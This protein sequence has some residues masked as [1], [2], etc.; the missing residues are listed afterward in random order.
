VPVL[1]NLL[2]ARVTSIT[3]THVSAQTAGGHGHKEVKCRS[4][5]VATST[6]AGL[7]EYFWRWQELEASGCKLTVQTVKCWPQLSLGFHLVNWDIVAD[8]KTKI[9][10]RMFREASNSVLKYRHN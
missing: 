10:H 2:G 7:L 9:F 6:D 4:L 8:A 5:E 1:H 3:C